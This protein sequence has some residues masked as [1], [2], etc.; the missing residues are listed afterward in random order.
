MLKPT[1]IGGIRDNRNRVNGEAE[2][3]IIAAGAKAF[4]SF[5]LAL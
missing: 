4:A 3:E 5:I 2:C 1:I